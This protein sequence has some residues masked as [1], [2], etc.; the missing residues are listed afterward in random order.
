M[1]KRSSLSVIR[2]LFIGMLTL[3]SCHL[4]QAV[5]DPTPTATTAVP[6]PTQTIETIPPTTTLTPTIT[7]SPTPLPPSPTPS[8]TPTPTWVYHDPGRVVAPILLYHHVNGENSDSRYTVS[9]PDF[10][11]QM[12]AL[13]EHGYTAITIS[14]LVDALLFGGDLPAKPVVITFDDGHH[15]VYDYAFPIMSEFGFPGVFYIVA[16]RI[17]GT[18]DF[19]NVAEIQTMI[20]AG[21]EIG[22]HGYTHLDITKDHASAP[23]EIGQS[24]V[25]LARALGTDIKTF[26]YPFG[27]VNPYVAQK[28]SDYGY[29]AGMGLGTSMT[30]N[31]GNVFYLNRIEIYGDYNLD[32]FI[33][34]ISQE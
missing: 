17:Y 26:A 25:D 29:Q 31:W 18:T 34:L 13:Y 30:H 22:S 11:N 1:R 33:Q 5:S 7:P 23:Y 9:I 10:R 16:N 32:K 12:Q 8:I 21:W 3:T 28:V 2:I 27:E 19:V 14:I 20:E 24:R 4:P 6:T 15:S